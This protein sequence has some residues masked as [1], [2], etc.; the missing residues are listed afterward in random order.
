MVSPLQSLA[1][2]IRPQPNNFGS[3]LAGLRS[4]G[5]QTAASQQRRGMINREQA[6]QNAGILNRIA[7]K[8]KGAD[9][10]QY[11]A[12]LQADMGLLS[13]MGITPEQL[14]Q[15][16][17]EDVDAVIAKTSAI[18]G[19]QAQDQNKVGARKIYS[20]GT[21]IQS[22]PQGPRVFSPSGELLSG[23]AA[24][25]QVRKANENEIELAGGKAEARGFGSTTGRGVAEARLELPQTIATAEGSLAVLDQ[26]I[27]HPGRKTATGASSRLDPRNYTPG[28][29]AYN[30]N[31]LMDQIQG[32]TFLQAYQSLR[33]G[34]QITEIE[35]KKA[36]QA[37]ARLNTAQSE[38]AFLKSLND[39]KEVIQTGIERAKKKAGKTEK[40]KETKEPQGFD[41]EYDPATGEFK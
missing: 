40:P 5:E 25:D 1:A 35:G 11:Q 3:R 29:E 33:G 7:T 15:I 30:F 10:S 37:I 13:Q 19:P 24:E 22:T 18:I 2:G 20:D 39:L 21:I 16:T 23:K 38:E 6:M 34:G 4:I 17:P 8:L 31:V 14:Q 32:R 26:A 9:P 36:E 27:N 12:I 28:T 41:L